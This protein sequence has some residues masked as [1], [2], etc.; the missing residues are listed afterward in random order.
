[1]PETTTIRCACGSV[2]LEARGAPI[3]S[4]V[5]YCQDCQDGGRRIEALPHA[6]PVVD[7]DGGTA[8][9]LYRKDRVR[10]LK[11]AALLQGDKLKETSVTNRMV[12]TCCNS[13]MLVN[14]DNTAMHWV[15]LYRARFPADAPPLQ[16][17]IQTKFKS[18]G[19][20]MPNDVPAYAT[21]PLSLV[22]KMI[23]AR[24]AMLFRR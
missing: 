24:I 17:R 7:P 10:N 6:P 8:Y 2:E 16:M 14:F 20:A 3:V 4:A 9:A 18:P 19:S 5:C 22:A 13:A 12:A 23:A 21:F 15:S 1:M 11:G